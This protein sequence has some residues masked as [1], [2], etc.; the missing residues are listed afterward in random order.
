[1]QAQSRFYYEKLILSQ[2]TP[3]WHIFIDIIDK[4]DIL[5]DGRNGGAANSEN[6][7]PVTMSLRSNL[8]AK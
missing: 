4:V 3:Q 7:K 6:N 1:L 2:K 5:S 8:A